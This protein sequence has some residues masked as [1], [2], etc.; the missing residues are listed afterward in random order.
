MDAKRFDHLTQVLAARLTRRHGLG[1]LGALGLATAAPSRETGAKKPRKK[2]KKKAPARCTVSQNAASVTTIVASYKGLSLSVVERAPANPTEAHTSVT[3]VREKR[4]LVLEITQTFGSGISTRIQ[5]RYGS[6]FQGF[7]ESD[8]TTDGVTVSGTI[9]GRAIVPFA[10]NAAPDTVEFQDGQPA[11]EA[12]IRNGLVPQLT[13]LFAQ[14]EKAATA[15]GRSRAARSGDVAAEDAFS[16]KCLLCKGGCSS[17]VAS[18]LQGASGLCTAALG[19]PFLG[20][21]L[22]AACCAAKFPI[23]TKVGLECLDGC[24]ESRTCCPVECGNQPDWTCCEEGQICLVAGDIGTFRCCRA[25]LTPCHGQNCCPSPQR[26][27]PNGACCIHPDFPCGQNCCGPFTDNCCN[28]VCCFG[29][30]LNGQCCA[31]PS[32]RC[33]NS[34]CAN[35]CCNN[36]C[37][38]AGEAC[39][40]TTGQCAVLCPPNQDFCPTGGNGTCCSEIQDCCLRNG[41]WGCRASGCVD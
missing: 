40:P 29:E 14:G 25:G 16:P 26:C 41:Q 13:K 37:C 27:M 5:T 15:C 4:A 28:G 30:C 23:C 21:A 9:D 35:A 1:L 18:C 33:G 36:V 20:L 11:P 39:H 24:R 3:T 12:T 34:C 22:Y 17:T 6:A 8:L 7:A 2:K 32:Q 38:A 19:V 10:V 31:R